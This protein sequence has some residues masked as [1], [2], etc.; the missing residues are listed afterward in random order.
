M[1]TFPCERHTW[2][3]VESDCFYLR[4]MEGLV[5]TTGSAKSNCSFSHFY[6]HNDTTRLV[7]LLSH[8]IMEETKTQ[9]KKQASDHTSS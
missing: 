7:L 1:P 2:D 6:P 4:F 8:L 9:V 3:G 5:S